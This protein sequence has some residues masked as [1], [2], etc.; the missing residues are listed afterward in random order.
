MARSTT[1]TRTTT[2]TRQ[3]VQDIKSALS[4]DGSTTY[5]TLPITPS[6][7]AF[8]VAFWVKIRAF[9]SNMRLVDW[10]IGGPADGFTIVASSTIANCLE[11][12]IRNGAA[13]VAQ[14]VAPVASLNTWYH[15]VL[16]YEVNSSKFYING[17]QVGATDTSCTMAAAAATTLTVGRRAP[18]PANF[19][20][21]VMSQ[22]LF[23]NNK[24]LTQQEINNLY[25]SG[26][27]PSSSTSLLPLDNGAGSIAYDTSGNGNNGTIT[28]ATYTSDAPSKARKMVGGNLIPNGDFSYVPKVNALTTT[29]SRWIDGTAGGAGAGFKIFDWGLR[30]RSNASNGAMFDTTTLYNGL[31]TMK[32][33]QP[34]TNGFVEVDLY[35]P[36]TNPTS[37][38]IPDLIP[39][40][41]STSY[42]YSYMMKTDVTSGSAT[43]GANCA[44]I[45]FA[46]SAGAALA[47]N[48]LS[49]VKTTTDWTYYTG[50]FTTNASTRYLDVE[51][52][53]YSNDGAATLV[54]DAWFADIR[55]T[56]TTNTTRT[57][58]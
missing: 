29:A 48:I 49:Y 47:T 36:G 19:F 10:Q 22:F 57:A 46:G 16:T 23:Y 24:V 53:I 2:S 5:F 4:F 25:Y 7:T 35:R 38:D 27:I 3:A 39:V 15:V 17:I 50:S 8:S 32:L 18:S 33:S 58:V 14:V 26:I 21:G 55:L 54:M 45:E 12:V 43:S 9:T 42:T 6:V 44:F 20:N 51:M 37:A 56:P 31:P 52:R 11:Y 40:L 1:S 30:K 28:G 13:A 34:I 41:P